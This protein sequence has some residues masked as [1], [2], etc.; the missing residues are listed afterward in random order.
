MARK[1]VGVGSVGTRAWVFL[2]VGREGKDPLVLQAKQAQ[3]SVLEPYLGTSEFEN[4]GERVVRGQWLSQAASDISLSWQRSEGLDG[5]D[6]DFYV[7][8]L[9]DWKA[10]ADLSTLSESGLHAYTR[11]WKP[12]PDAGFSTRQK[13]FEPLTFGSVDAHLPSGMAR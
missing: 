3:A 13:G 2:F 8:Q 7:R 1:V 6:H 9:W 4:H 5:N 11:A 12:N 10:S